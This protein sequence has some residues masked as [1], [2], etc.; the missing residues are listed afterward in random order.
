MSELVQGG[1]TSQGTAAYRARVADRTA[2]DHFR[3]WRGLTVSSIGLGT[4]LGDDDAATDALYEEATVRA[5]EL[6]INVLDSAINYRCQRSERAVGRALARAAELKFAQRPEL[7]ITTKGGFLPFDGARPEDTRQYIEETWVKPGIFGWDELVAGCHCL[8]PR[9]ITDQLERSRAN[10]RLGTIDVYYLHNPE[11]QLAHVTRNVFLTRMRAAFEALER[12]VAEGKIGVYGTA[13]WNGYRQPADADDRL[14]LDELV[15]LAREVGGDAHHFRAVQ[16]PL[17]LS[18][19]EAFNASNQFDAVG[20]K[21]PLLEA[22]VELGVYVMT[23]GS[24]QQGRL[25]RRLSDGLRARLDP[26][27]VIDA[28]RALQFVR[29]TPGVG[30]ALI[31]TK[32]VAHV[33]EAAGVARVSPMKPEAIRALVK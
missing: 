3:A 30:T 32:R 17:N 31:G 6:G 10:L 27:L 4:Y 15:A 26:S 29:S 18:M 22:A 16:L 9:F 20:K 19:L 5:L 21:R 23:S 11:T 28:Q 1:A 24:I 7:V 12:A 8:S 14:S 25:A 2:P 13:T 33:E